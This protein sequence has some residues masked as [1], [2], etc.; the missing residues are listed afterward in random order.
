MAASSPHHGARACVIAVALLLPSLGH[1]RAPGPDW[2]PSLAA[3]FDQAR[4][5]GRLV[6]VDVR[7]DWCAACRKMD[8]T[9]F[10][11]PRVLATLGSHYVAAQG[12]IDRDPEIMCRYGDFGVPAVVIL[13]ADG[14]EIIRRRGYLEPDWLY[15]LLSAVAD[16]PS[17]EAHQ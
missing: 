14:T 15:W 9:G 10:R 12:D 4:R 16:D 2:Q 13:N 11:D 3:A 6:L 5:D 1:A 8:E 7:A 17:P